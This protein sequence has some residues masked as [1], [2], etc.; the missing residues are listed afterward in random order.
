MGALVTVI[1]TRAMFELIDDDDG[2]TH[3]NEQCDG[4]TMMFFS[5]RPHSF[6]DKYVAVFHTTI[7]EWEIF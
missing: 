4:E 7:A 5:D 6:L 1:V 2:C 3:H